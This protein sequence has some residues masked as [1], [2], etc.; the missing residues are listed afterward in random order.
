MKKVIIVGA[1]SGIGYEL[2]KKFSQQGWEI[3]ITARRQPLL[4]TLAE[5]FPQT[6]W[7]IKAMDT[8]QQEESQKKLLDL[9]EEM[10]GI[11]VFVYNAGIGDNST[12]WEKEHHLIQVNAVGFAALTNTVFHYFKTQKIPGQ[13]VGISSVASQRGSRMAI[14]YS[15]T[16][17]FMSNYLQG[18]RQLACHRKLPITVTDIRPG[19]IETPMTEGQKGMFWVAK[20]ERAAELIYSA[21]VKKKSVAYIP[22]RWRWVAWAIRNM[23]ELVW[24]KW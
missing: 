22:G 3:G 24:N 6:K 1:S 9:I 23:P 18:L 11:D 4:E 17:A 2:A 8:S 14:A 16:K 12:R 19:Y 7:H 15:A 5:Q 21:I 10:G 13:I 20:S